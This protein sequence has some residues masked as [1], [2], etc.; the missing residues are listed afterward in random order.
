M[1]LVSWPPLLGSPHHFAIFS[2]AC[3]PAFGKF[4]NVL[5]SL[6][7]CC[8]GASLV[9][10]SYAWHT[11]LTSW[12]RS[13]A[14]GACDKIPCH[15]FRASQQRVASAELFPWL[16][17]LLETSVNWGV[18]H[19]YLFCW[20][21]FSRQQ[22]C[23]REVYSWWSL[24]SCGHDAE[25]TNEESKAMTATRMYQTLQSSGCSRKHCGILHTSR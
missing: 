8:L 7:C 5:C 4:R 10:V 9:L 24:F 19:F 1:V 22:A 23:L 11:A 12:Q 17:S 13:M 21:Q 14:R 25:L 15:A 6:I 18:H 20:R 16:I 2:F 3:A